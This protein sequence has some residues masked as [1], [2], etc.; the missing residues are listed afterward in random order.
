MLERRPTT[1]FIPMKN[2]VMP[3]MKGDQAPANK[4]AGFFMLSP[5][6]STNFL[7]SD[8]VHIVRL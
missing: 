8:F 1:F 6:S 4:K 2:R 3:I 7:R 5:N